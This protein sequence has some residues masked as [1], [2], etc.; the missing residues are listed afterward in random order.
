MQKLVAADSVPRTHRDLLEATIVYAAKIERIASESLSHRL[1]ALIKL[2]ISL[3]I[4]NREWVSHC[5]REAKDVASDA[6]IG[7]AVFA[8]SGMKAGAAT[9]YG[10]LVFKYLDP[11]GVVDSGKTQFQSDRALMT[12]FR[13]ASPAAFD[14]WQQRMG[15]SARVVL[16]DKEYE[17]I[18]IACSTVS[19]CVYCLEYHGGLA[20]KA[21]AT[22]R[23]VAD[24]LHLAISMRA[25]A[26]LVEWQA[27]CI[28]PV[29]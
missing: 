21:G 14:A 13:T 25:V 9:A 26:G 23:E 18:C 27:C 8:A 29:S 7:D 5:L 24:T 16:S 17:L 12:Q 15:K 28:P 2:A 6:D 20:R 11:N 19:Q 10:R 3:S 22:D 1:T 4:P